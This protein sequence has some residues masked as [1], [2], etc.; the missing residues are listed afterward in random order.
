M[1]MDWKAALVAVGLMVGT[2]AVAKAQ[3]AGYYETS[4]VSYANTLA[5]D[6]GCTTA[7]DACGTCNTCNTGCCSSGINWFGCCGHGDEFKLFGENSCGIEIGGWVSAGYYGNARGVRTNSGN[8]PVGFREISNAA[9]LN[10][11]WIYAEKAADAETYCFDLGFRIDA[12]F[13]ADGPDTQAF[14]H[15]DRHTWDNGWDSSTDGDQDLYGSAIPQ[16]YLEA[17]WGDWNVKAGHFYTL[18]G[19]EVVQA[20]DNFF[21]SHAYTMYY[22]EPFT[23]WGALAEYGGFDGVSLYGGWVSGWDTAF[24]QYEAQSMFLGGYSMD[25]SDNLSL[26][27]MATAGSFGKQGGDL[28]MQSV[29]LDANLGAGWNYVFQ[30]DLGYN[31]NTEFLTTADADKT[32]AYWYGVNQYLFKEINECWSIGAR[33]EWF[34]DEDGVRVLS[35]TGAGNV[36][37]P[38]NFY[39]LTLGANWRPSANLTVR[40]E[41]RWDK[42]DDREASGATPFADGTRDN[43]FFSGVDVIYTF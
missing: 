4:Q 15:G 23:H 24:D 29:V 2:S 32:T 14:G 11:A 20:P 10:Q 37:V 7:A 38:G 41:V 9:T 25:L 33:A 6:C 43:A 13:G 35:E 28:Y 26:S 3:D 40:P 16:L 22:G 39:S 36:G 1:K 42:F 12:M 8:G 19:Y 31:K 30:T 27:H 18:I 5:D 17:A 34:C 21:Y